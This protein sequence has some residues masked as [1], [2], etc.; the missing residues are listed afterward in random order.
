MMKTLAV[1]YS[2]EKDSILFSVIENKFFSYESD[3][4]FLHEKYGGRQYYRSRT[5]LSGAGYLP[6]G[7]DLVLFGFYRVDTKAAFQK[8]EVVHLLDGNQPVFGYVPIQA[9]QGINTKYPVVLTDG[10]RITFVWMGDVVET[11]LSWEQL[12]FE[13]KEL[14]YY[15]KYGNGTYHDFGLYNPNKYRGVRATRF[16]DL[17]NAIADADQAVKE[18]GELPLFYKRLH[19]V[20]CN[21]YW[22]YRHVDRFLSQKWTT[23]PATIIDEEIVDGW[24]QTDE[25]LT[26]RQGRY[27]VEAF[28]EVERATLSDGKYVVKGETPKYIDYEKDFSILEWYSVNSI[29][30]HKE[31]F[32]KKLRAKAREDYIYARQRSGIDTKRLME[33]NQDL[34]V[35]IQD[36][37]EA[38]N[39]LVGI[40]GFIKRFQIVP[41]SKGCVTFSTLLKNKEIN[42]MV[43]DFN[44][45]K[46]I[47]TKVESEG[48]TV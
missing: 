20:P 5:G 14:K 30:D 10:G 48:G 47:A 44:F 33:N 18:A 3:N 21:G 27:K 6:L 37:L 22:F 2:G 41:D 26:Y 34:V 36:S 8:R 39:C 35:C 38:G 7:N 24:K 42:R 9:H 29:I 1:E 15:D 40:E 19:I 43:K 16:I 32:K 17:R 4:T 13:R 12:E 11:L 25:H 23:D 28:M 46:V 45:Q 31:Y